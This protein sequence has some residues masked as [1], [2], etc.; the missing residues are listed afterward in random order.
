MHKGNLFLIGVI[1]ILFTTSACDISKPEPESEFE[2]IPGPEFSIP[3]SLIST[4]VPGR[5]TRGDAQ[6]VFE[7]FRAGLGFA[8]W[9]VDF[10]SL[11]IAGLNDNPIPESG[12]FVSDG[13]LVVITTEPEREYETIIEFY[14]GETAVAENKYM[15]ISYTKDINKGEA[16]LDVGTKYPEIED[17]DR[18]KI[19]YDGTGNQPV[20]KGWLTFNYDIA[21][22]FIVY[23][24]SVYFN[25]V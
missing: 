25:A 3:D 15:Q 22:V 6:N 14:T 4:E 9:G 23:P 24:I 7:P 16:V 1:I 10:V 21:D 2:G 11:I 17:V 19:Y 13:E 20:L 8:Q 18:L 5:V 12:E